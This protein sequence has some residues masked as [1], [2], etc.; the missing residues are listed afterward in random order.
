M[1]RVG[2]KIRDSSTSSSSRAR[3]ADYQIPRSVRLYT[4]VTKP[5][6]DWFQPTSATIA[7]GTS[8]SSPAARSISSRMKKPPAGC[9]AGGLKI[10]ARE[11]A[12]C[13]S[14]REVYPISSAEC[15]AAGLD[16]ARA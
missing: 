5:S 6:R 1:S 15:Q 3:S 9:N 12:P 4:G 7:A 8:G 2:K 10:V 11:G 14:R 16:R 13:D